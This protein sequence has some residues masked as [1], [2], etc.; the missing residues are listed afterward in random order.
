MIL[1][2]HVDLYFPIPCV[3]FLYI[4]GCALLKAPQSEDAPFGRIYCASV[5]VVAPRYEPRTSMVCM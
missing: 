1:S 4:L 2:H 3:P 5:Q